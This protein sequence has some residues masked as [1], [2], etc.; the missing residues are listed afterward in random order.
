MY[1]YFFSDNGGDVIRGGNN[2]PLRGM[3]ETMWEG[4]VRGVGFVGGPALPAQAQGK[5]SH[6]LI[7]VSDWFP[8]LLHV[9]AG[10]Y[11]DMELDGFNVWDT[12]R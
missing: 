9:A 7:H 4:G 10:N 11:T 5:V 3:K 8:T 6:E 12:L 2:W 1:T